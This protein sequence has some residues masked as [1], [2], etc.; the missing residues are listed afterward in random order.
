MHS[1]RFATVAAVIA[2][3]GCGGDDGGA[4]SGSDATQAKRGLDRALAA[5]REGDRSEAADEV[6]R[7]RDEHFS[8]VEPT[9]RDRALAKRLHA[10]FY[11]DVPRLIEQGVTVSALA[12]R[13]A[14][15]EEQLDRAVAD[16]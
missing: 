9:L 5:Y 16:R 13:L 2:L 1:M 10:A 12:A 3:A 7:A 4:G 8:R 15:V 11:E 14:A 6:G